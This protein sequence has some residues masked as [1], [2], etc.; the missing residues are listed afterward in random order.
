M[1]VP[2]INMMPTYMPE[3]RPARQAPAEKPAP[4]DVMKTEPPVDI[5]AILN[6]LTGLSATLNKK[7][8]FSMNEKLD[9]V[10]VKVIDA[11]TEEVIKEIPP[12]EIQHVHERIR[13][14]LG[15][16]FDEIA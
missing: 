13:E 8:S 1:D 3:A 11:D 5:Q 10:V 2:A 9:Q 14:V 4:V 12:S 7:L 6:D 15:I 16:L